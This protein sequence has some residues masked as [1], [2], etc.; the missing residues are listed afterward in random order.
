M[1]G[2]EYKSR[3]Q[4]VAPVDKGTFR[5]SI[6]LVR[7]RTDT[8]M[9]VIVGSSLKSEGG[10]PY[11]VFLEM[12]TARIAGGRVLAWE[13]GQPPIRDWPAKTAN[14]REFSGLHG[15]ARAAHLRKREKMKSI[16]L[17]GEQMPFFRPIGYDIAPKVID[18]CRDALNG[19]L[20]ERLDGKKF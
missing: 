20:K 19:V 5:Q 13:Q 9:T 18:D 8:T 10:A 3:V 7:E 6:Q 14:A 16:G 11:P 17:E 4:G 1:W 12:G 2:A 15:A